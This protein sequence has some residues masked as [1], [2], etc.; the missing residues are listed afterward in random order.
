MKICFGYD[1]HLL[2]PINKKS[3]EETSPGIDLVGIKLYKDKY[4]TIAHSSGDVVCH[5]IA[6]ALSSNIVHKT[7]GELFPDNLEHTRLMSG[8]DILNSTLDICKSHTNNL[9]I[10]NIDI[11]I[12]TNEVKIVEIAEDIRKNLSKALKISVDD[13]AV[14]GK[15]RVGYDTMSLECFVVILLV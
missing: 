3:T 13:I 9:R 2:L 7:I 5:A 14:K 15:T 1:K 12:I 10:E 8:L 4:K 11:S 6:D